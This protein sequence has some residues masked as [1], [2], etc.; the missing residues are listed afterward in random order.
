MTNCP[1][2]GS[3]LNPYVW[4]CEYCGTYVWDTTAM[5][6]EDGHPCYVKMKTK[7]GTI[8]TLAKPRLETAETYSVSCDATD[9]IGTTLMSHTA[10]RGC[11][12]N[13]R[14]ECM[15]GEKGELMQYVPNNA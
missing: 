6:F 10:M 13:V 14:F 7:Y 2:C 15:P 5:D 1:N 3:V 11:N 4:K 12:I 9:A 8:T